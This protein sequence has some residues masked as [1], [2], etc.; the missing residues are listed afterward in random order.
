MKMFWEKGFDATSMNDLAAATGMAKPGLYANFGDKEALYTMAL[1][2]YFDELGSPLLDDLAR[3]PDPLVV[4]VRRF[5]DAIAASVVDKTSPGGCFIVNSVIECANRP[6]PL[7]NLARAFD[8]KRS[9][10]FLDRFRLAKRQG[11]LPAD[12]DARALAEFFA[13]QVLALAVMGRAGANRKSIDRV[14][15]VAMKVI[16]AD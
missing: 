6:A 3:S 13:G 4:V 14:I 11:E 15:D 8:A 7:E 1:T 5:L 2:H 16:P 12:A 10:A 9:A